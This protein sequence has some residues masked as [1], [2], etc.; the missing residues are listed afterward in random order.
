[1][2]VLPLC[3]I[4]QLLQLH[5]N[6]RVQSYEKSLTLRSNFGELTQNDRK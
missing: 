3:I 5:T 4:S 6:Y 1:M 2:V